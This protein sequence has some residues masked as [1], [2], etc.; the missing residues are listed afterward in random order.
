MYPMLVSSSEDVND[1]SDQNNNSILTSLTQSYAY[2]NKQYR[3]VWCAILFLIHV[4]VIFSLA[5]TK[6]ISALIEPGN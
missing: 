6:G 3:D 4:A 2:M 1:I 5:L